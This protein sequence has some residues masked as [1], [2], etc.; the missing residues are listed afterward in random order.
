LQKSNDYAIIKKQ[1]IELVRFMKLKE[2]TK[3]IHLRKLGKS[4]SEIRKWVNFSKSTLNLWLKGIEF[5][6]E[7]KVRTI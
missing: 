2:K 1:I 4:Y 3:A 6:P 7:Q 5:A